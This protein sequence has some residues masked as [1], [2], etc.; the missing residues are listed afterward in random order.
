MNGANSR[1]IGS[2]LADPLCGVPDAIKPRTFRFAHD[3]KVHRVALPPTLQAPV[4]LGWS[5]YLLAPSLALVRRIAATKP[6]RWKPGCRQRSKRSFATTTAACC[7]LHNSSKPSGKP[8]SK[9]SAKPTKPNP[10]MPNSKAPAVHAGSKQDLV[11]VGR[12]EPILDI[13]RDDG[14]T[15]SV[16]GAGRRIAT[17]RSAFC[18]G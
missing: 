8:S 4:G 14:S 13:I 16:R 3:G 15:F 6:A 1:R 18:R 2:C 5:L 11:L 7:G 17:S 10:L 12:I 9:R